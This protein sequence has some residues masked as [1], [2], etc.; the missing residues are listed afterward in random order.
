MRTPLAGARFLARGAEPRDVDRGSVAPQALEPEELAA[1][2]AED[3]DDEVDVVHQD[4]VAA[5]AAFDVRGAPSELLD[6]P[7]LDA[8][9]DR[10]DLAVGGSVADEEEVGDVAAT[11]KVENLS[12]SARTSGLAE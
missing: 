3:V 12:I 7:F 5:A 8:V 1:I 9:D 11:A 10:L 2:L 6:Q 4:P